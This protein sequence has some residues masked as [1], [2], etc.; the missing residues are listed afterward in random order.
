VSTVRQRTRRH[1]TTT[2]PSGVTELTC[3]T[4]QRRAEVQVCSPMPPPLSLHHH[5]C[6]PW[7][8]L[9]AIFADQIT[10]SKHPRYE[11]DETPESTRLSASKFRGLSLLIVKQIWRVTEF[12][13]ALQWSDFGSNPCGSQKQPWLFLWFPFNQIEPCTWYMSRYCR[14]PLLNLNPECSCKW[15]SVE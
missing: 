15:E 13:A 5:Y 7:A 14:L 11:P 8:R 1:W 9:C 2:E 12:G 6:K 4:D 3:E 10:Y